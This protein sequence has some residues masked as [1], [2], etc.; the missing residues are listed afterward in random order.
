MMILAEANLQL[1]EGLE[2]WN[3]RRLAFAA[4]FGVSCGCMWYGLYISVFRVVCPNAITFANRTFADK[5]RDTAGQRD[6]V[7]QVFIDIFIFSPIC[8]FPVFY[9][10]KALI[11]ESMESMDKLSAIREG[12]KKYRT[13]FWEDN[14]ANAVFWFPGDFF[15]FTIPA[16][17]RMPCAYALGFGW[18][19]MLFWF[20]VEKLPEGGDEFRGLPLMPLETAGIAE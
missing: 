6:L 15:V 10:S 13:T 17:L 20:R 3:Q 18:T 16:W 1:V 7:K 12:L 19:S 2:K 4:C 5:L 8:Y 9:C 11:H 14:A